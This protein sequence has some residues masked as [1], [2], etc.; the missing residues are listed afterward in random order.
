VLWIILGVVGVLVL[1]CVAGIFVFVNAVT[2]SP[3]VDTVNRYY[4]AMENQDYATAYQYLDPGISLTF[5]GASQQ[6]TQAL[7]TQAAQAYDVQKGKISSYS[8]TSTNLNSSTSS[9]STAAIT[10]NVTRNGSS[11]DVH[12]QLKQEGN[13]W[14]IVSFDSL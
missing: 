2:H 11:Y 9:G 3:A 6:I 14:K 4:T 12:L 1:A 8:I 10:V 13:A 7:F 5:L